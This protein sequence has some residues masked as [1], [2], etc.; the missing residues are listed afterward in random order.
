MTALHQISIFSFLKNVCWTSL[1]VQWL[2]LQRQGKRH[3]SLLDWGTKFLTPCG[4]AKR[5]KKKNLPLFWHINTGLA[6]CC[7][8]FLNYFARV[9]IWK[10]VWPNESPKWEDDNI[11]SWFMPLQFAASCP[12]LVPHKELHFLL[13][14]SYLTGENLSL[15]FFKDSNKDQTS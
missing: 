10:S 15:L 8:V 13:S 5:L 11:A 1:V 6:S 9:R 14:L 2:K 7:M 12:Y 4:M 3:G